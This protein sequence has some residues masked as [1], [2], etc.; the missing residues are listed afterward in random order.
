MIASS[1][2][3]PGADRSLTSLYSVYPSYAVVRCTTPKRLDAGLQSSVAW[4]KQK[5][6]R[7]ARLKGEH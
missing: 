6:E 1:R 4:G 5:N 3:L 2:T 7:H